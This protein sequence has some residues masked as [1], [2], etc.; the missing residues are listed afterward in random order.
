[1]NKK[2]LLFWNI[3][4]L[5]TI[6]CAIL[7]GINIKNVEIHPITISF[8]LLFQSI[9]IF[10][11][12][13]ILIKC[14]I[15]IFHKK[16]EFQITNNSSNT[17]V[18][19]NYNLKSYDKQ[20]VNQCLENFYNSFIHNLSQNHIGVLVSATDN[21]DIVNYE[22]E[23]YNQYK[24]NIYELLISKVKK[25][26]NKS[27]IFTTDIVI[28]IDP[29]Y[30]N[31]SD[32]FWNQY[33]F[34]YLKNN[35]KKICL[36]KSN[37]FIYLRR[38]SKALKKCGQYQDLILLSEGYSKGYTYIDKQ[39]YGNYARNINENLFYDSLSIDKILGK[40]FKYTLVMDS[41]SRINNGEVFK[42]VNIAEQYPEYH[43]I[44]PQIQFYDQHNFFQRIHGIFQKK[45]NKINSSTSS[46]LKHSN[47]FGKGLIVNEKYFEKCIG[48]PENLIEYVPI[49]C[50]SHDTFESMALSTLYCDKLNI[51]E[52]TPTSLITWNIRELRWN[53]GDIIVAKHIYPKLFCRG[54]PSYSRNKFNLNF[55]ESYF[56]LSPVR[57]LI[58][59]PL[60]LI[61]IFF[62]MF[63]PLYYPYIPFLYMCLTIIIIPLFV[64]FRNT[65]F[66]ECLIILATMI[67]Q[68]TPESLLGTI[69]LIRIIY[70]LLTNS[71][72]WISQ[73]KIE[74]DIK[75]Q[76]I[77]KMSFIYFGVYAFVSCLILI[78]IYNKFPSFNFFLSCIIILPFYS[79]VVGKIKIVEFP[80]IGLRKIKTIGMSRNNNTIT[81]TR[82]FHLEKKKRFTELLKKLKFSSIIFKTAN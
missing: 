27:N 12:T 63:V 44:Q 49:N 1:M 41:D 66:K 35:Y 64:N 37:E 65:S 45:S 15:Y 43:I 14:M 31:D 51:F 76:G 23:Q 73:K 25:Y 7:N 32:I 8:Y 19:I 42:M 82:T 16:K 77:V 38:V 46:F 80:K 81:N 40:K 53:Y 56:A 61:F 10:V 74:D 57:I 2:G 11:S 67:F 50:I 22:I 47:F 17:K 18:I 75:Q 5:N 3:S 52:E 70:K 28:N 48:T 21:I 68:Y 59:K 60:L 79:I 39:L 69:R 36:E 6:G 58:T 34:D 29:Y 30:Q 54:T 72:V 33:E 26:L 55:K 9:C 62:S 78:F 24:Q 4:L 71:N 20:S 13:E